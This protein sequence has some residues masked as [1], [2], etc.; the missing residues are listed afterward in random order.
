[1]SL[2]RTAALVVGI[3]L[4]LLT[5][6]CGDK[7]IPPMPHT[8]ALVGPAQI[9]RVGKNSPSGIALQ[10]W[11][12]VQVGD[13]ASAAGFYHQ[14]VLA[15]IG[16]ATVSGALEQQHEHLE[17]L[18]PARLTQSHTPLGVEVV[19]KGDNTVDGTRE[20]KTEVVSFLLRRDTLGWRIAYDTILSEA[21]PA[22]VYSRV[23]DRVAP[24]STTPS[25]QARMASQKIRDVY[26]GLFAPGNEQAQRQKSRKRRSNLG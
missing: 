26:R 17:V 3:P 23:Q 16:F 19:V 21:L 15:A 20:N 9:A 13:A 6:G 8:Q 14:R 5:S 24:G 25:R 2:L 11:R 22:Y 18:R 1:M 12:A 4:A 10:L 7:A